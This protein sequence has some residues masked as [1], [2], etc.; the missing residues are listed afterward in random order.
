MYKRL[1]Y[2]FT[3][4]LSIPTV[5]ASDSINRHNEAGPSNRADS[6]DSIEQYIL[7]ADTFD[8]AYH[9]LEDFDP[10]FVA[11]NIQPEKGET[12]YSSHDE[13]IIPQC[14]YPLDDMYDEAF[15]YLQN[16]TPFDEDEDQT[17]DWYEAADSSS[18][19]RRHHDTDT[20][21]TSMTSE[22]SELERKERLIGHPTGE[23]SEAYDP[24]A[25]L[26]RGM[27]T[28]PVIIPRKG[29]PA[30]KIPLL[31]KLDDVYRSYAKEV[32]C[33]FN[34]AKNDLAV[35]AN[36]ALA[37]QLLDDEP[38]RRALAAQKIIDLLPEHIRTR[39]YQYRTKKHSKAK[40]LLGKDLK[41]TIEA[42]MEKTKKSLA[43]AD[44]MI[45]QV[46]DKEIATTIKRY[47]T[48]DEGVMLI[49]SRYRESRN[50]R[51]RPRDPDIVT[52]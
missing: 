48:F 30:W 27:S 47:A 46:I 34:K 17:G 49:I 33:G 13:S 20:L 37:W 5:H 2:I 21:A 38:V 42:V 14:S 29:C 23:T 32:N 18:G 43:M 50:T 41:K 6:H 28:R 31:G 40:I 52:T 7:N 44:V 15:Q 22:A 39:K 16:Y 1:I 35:V 4:L 8:A 10:F 19:S 51:G 11:D 45:N 36:E 25:H 3:S 12:R 26:R 9:N 24:Y